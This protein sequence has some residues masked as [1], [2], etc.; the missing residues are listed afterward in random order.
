[1]RAIVTGASALILAAGLAG[2]QAGT[3]NGFALDIPAGWTDETDQAEAKA[4]RTEFELVLEGPEDDGTPATI[5]ITRVAL[6]KGD[7]LQRAVELQRKEARGAAPTAAAT[8]TLAGEPAQ[9]FD[10]GALGKQGRLLAAAHDGHL[11]ALTLTSDDGAFSDNAEV[12]DRI[13]AS[14]VWEAPASS[15]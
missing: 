10:Y 15:K 12:L 8:T 13:R 14:W 3:T 7:S 9:T 6:R 4:G 2:C 5:A 1:M 11:Y